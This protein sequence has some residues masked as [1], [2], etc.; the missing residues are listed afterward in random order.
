MR[1]YVRLTY[2]LGFENSSTNVCTMLLK[3]TDAY[4]FNKGSSVLCTFLDASKAFDRVNY[5]NMFRFLI[6]RDLP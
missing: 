1:I 6:E 5:C 2:N 4:Y 3:E